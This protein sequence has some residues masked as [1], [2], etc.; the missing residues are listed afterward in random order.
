MPPED[1]VVKKL[2]SENEKLSLQLEQLRTQLNNATAHPD[3]EE[4]VSHVRRNALTEINAM[5]EAE[6]RRFENWKRDSVEEVE[7][8]VTGLILRKPKSKLSK[9][10]ICRDVSVAL[11]KTL[12]GETTGKIHIS[13]PDSAMKYVLPLVVAA[14][15]CGAYA[16]HSKWTATRRPAAVVY[17]PPPAKVVVPP[18][19]SKPVQAQVPP[20]SYG[21]QKR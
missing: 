11:R 4:E 8:T 5:K 14:L 15:L 16:F 13:D 9:E 6:A 12:L 18:R 20:K 21:K 19:H 3:E 17:V 2:E 10:E 1:V 7:K